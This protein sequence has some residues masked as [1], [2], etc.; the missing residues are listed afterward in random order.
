MGLMRSLVRNVGTLSKQV[1]PSSSP[2]NNTEVG[3]TYTDAPDVND[4]QAVFPQWFF[5]SRLG[6]PRSVDVLKLRKLAQSPWVQMVTNTFKKQIQTIDWDIVPEDE[7]DEIDRSADIKKCMDF[8]KKVNNNQQTIDDIN[9]ESITDIAE[10]DAGVFNYVYTSDSYTIGEIPVYNT[11]GKIIEYD[12]GLILKPLGQRELRAVKSVDG[13]SMLKQVDIHK[14]LLQYWQ[15]SFKHPRQNP[16][17]FEKDEISYLMMNPKSYDVYGFAPT[18]AIQQVLELL[19]QGTRYN[20]D[21]YTNNAIPDLLISLPK[22]PKAQL[23]VLKR[24]WNR[25]YKNKPHQVGFINWAIDKILK[26]SDNNRDLEWLDG[27]KWYFRLVFGVYGVSPEEAGF[28]EDSTKATGDSQ[29]RVTIRNALKPYLKKYEQLHTRKTITEIL[30]REDHGLKFVY[31]PKEHELERVEFE[32]DMLELDHGTLTINEFRRKKGREPAEWGDDPLRRP[33]DPSSSFTNFGEFP[34]PN[35]NSNPSEDEEANKKFRKKV[36]PPEVSD[37]MEEINKVETEIE[38][39]TVSKQKN[40]LDAGED[41]IIE[42]KDYSDFLLK[43]F[44]TMEKQVLKALPQIESELGT[45][46]K[47][48]GSFMRDLFNVV[49][50]TA[51]ASQ[52]RRFIKRDLI[53]GLVSVENEVDMDIGFTDVFQDKLNRLASQQIDGH[54]ING[55]KWPGIKGVTKEIQAEVIKT[56]Q[57]GISE[58]AGLDKIRDNIQN[59]FDNFSEWRSEMIART[60]TT[61]ITN[62]GKIL[63]YQETGIEG[64]KVWDA[65]KP[66][67][68]PR[69]SKICDRLDGQEVP[70]D[71]EFVDPGTNKRYFSPPG[72]PN[73]RSTVFFKPKF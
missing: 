52:V 28:T 30:G 42:A 2:I 32:Q 16:T 65:A 60:E 73:C 33:F 35:S 11:W 27:Q 61:R 59:K 63:A 36:E 57:S 58:G 66:R 55:R 38:S 9:A 15:Y 26:L 3:L 14:N 34:N 5:S 69:C 13:A 68:C 24:I 44:S 62:E 70:L 10:I 40:V 50:T 12:L 56:V 22:L 64:T 53:S 51:F 43:F 19:I 39:Q 71:A 21:L 72:H 48:V 45:S 7:E 47:T 67:G 8:F 46:Q 41:L 31:R 1:L 6:Q 18:Q 54:T 4:R 17:R 37:V 29:E 25:N 20:K 49:N 23:R